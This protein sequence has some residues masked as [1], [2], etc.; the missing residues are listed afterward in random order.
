MR[1]T[2]T[3]SPGSMAASSAS[4]SGV[5]VCSSAIATPP[6]AKRGA[7]IAIRRHSGG[8]RS[9]HTSVPTATIR[10][11]ARSTGARGGATVATA[12]PTASR[13]AH[14]SNRTGGR[15]SRSGPGR[16]ASLYRGKGCYLLQGRRPD[17]RYLL[18]L[19]HGGELPVGLPVLHDALGRGRPD[20]GQLV[21]LLDI[22]GIYVYRERV[23]R[24]VL[25]LLQGGGVD[26]LRRPLRH[27][28]RVERSTCQHDHDQHRHDRVR[29]VTR[30]SAGLRPPHARTTRCR[31][32]SVVSHRTGYRDTRR[33]ALGGLPSKP[34]HVSKSPGFARRLVSTRPVG[35][36]S[37]LQVASA[38]ALADKLTRREAPG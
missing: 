13:I 15:R 2:S 25:Y 24:V 3:T 21:E 26:D 7:R 11:A 6:T 9:R 34:Q 18:E 33:E 17:P 38:R 19:V 30:E 1:P 28:R 8:T 27:A 22:R 23:L 36:W 12:I 5:P 10:P 4:G 16:L 32:E 31:F 14:R 37:A 29:P 20:L 35:R